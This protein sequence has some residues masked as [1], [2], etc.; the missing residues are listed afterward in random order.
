M[1]LDDPAELG[2]RAAVIAAAQHHRLAG[3]I[4][5]WLGEL[6]YS[7]TAERDATLDASPIIDLAVVVGL[8]PVAHVERVTVRRHAVA[9]LLVLPGAVTDVVSA[10]DRATLVAL[11]RQADLIA[12]TDALRLGELL[13][14][15]DLAAPRWHGGPLVT[16]GAL[17]RHPQRWRDALDATVSNCNRVRTAYRLQTIR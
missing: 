1:A 6:G 9:V 10:T 3:E 5:D 12:A 7:A 17:V 8:P 2:P 16:D 11:A 14:D 15:V 4:V 13:R